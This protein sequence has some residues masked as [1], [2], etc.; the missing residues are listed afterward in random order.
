MV[1]RPNFASCGQLAPERT[2]PPLPTRVPLSGRLAR[3]VDLQVG[4]SRRDKW[5]SLAGGIFPAALMGHAGSPPAGKRGFR[6]SRLARNAVIDGV[7][8][9]QPRDCHVPTSRICTCLHGHDGIITVNHVGE[10]SRRPPHQVYRAALESVRAAE[11]RR[12]SIG[13]AKARI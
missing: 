1:H 8:L 12:R 10:D 9:P 6:S 4:D 5:Q 2:M 11:A 13:K 3:S 7:C